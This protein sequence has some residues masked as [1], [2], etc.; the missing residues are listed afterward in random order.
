MLAPVGPGCTLSD[1]IVRHDGGSQD[2]YYCPYINL[3]AS[4]YQETE[5]V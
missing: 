2:Y 3:S 5:L 4:G 1:V